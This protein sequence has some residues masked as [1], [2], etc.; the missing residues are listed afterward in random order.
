[1]TLLLLSALLACTETA[2]ALAY[3][4]EQAATPEPEPWMSDDPAVTPQEDYNP[5]TVAGAA[6]DLSLGF[7]GLAPGDP[8]TKR[9]EKHDRCSAA[10][11]GGWLC[12]GGTVGAAETHYTHY[13]VGPHGLDNVTILAKGRANCDALRVAVA[14]YGPGEA[15]PPGWGHGDWRWTAAGEVYASWVEPD[16]TGECTFLVM[17]HETARLNEAAVEAAS[18][19]A[20]VGDL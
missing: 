5:A 11:S 19:A 1:M 14:S 4:L 16:Y 13:S 9:P 3:E 6:V 17:Y 12:F 2:G 20:A 15:V 18:K 7:R 8:M 10:E